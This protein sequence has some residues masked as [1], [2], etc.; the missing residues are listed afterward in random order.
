[1]AIY[2]S[3]RVNEEGTQNIKGGLGLIIDNCTVSVGTA[4]VNNDRIKLFT[5]PKGSRV[6]GL[7][8]QGV[9]VQSGTDSLFSIGDEADPD[10]FQTGVINLRSNSLDTYIY[11]IPS[12]KTATTGIFNE[13]EEDTDVELKITTAGTGMTTG[14]KINAV[15]YYF[16]AE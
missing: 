3:D 16:R 12:E 7:Q 13:Y 15:I 1:M 11:L 10:R 9:G 14:G 4:L 2:Y 6:L 8:V 5:L